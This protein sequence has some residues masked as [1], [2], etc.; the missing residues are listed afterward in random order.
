[1]CFYWVW[2]KKASGIRKTIAVIKQLFGKDVKDDNITS[3][4]QR[5]MKTI[6]INEKLEVYGHVAEL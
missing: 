2:F 1:M 6:K 3:S 5:V 4:L